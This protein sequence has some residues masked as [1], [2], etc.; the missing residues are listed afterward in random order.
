MRVLRRP[1][2]LDALAVLARLL[3]GGVWIW[4]G[5][6]K[7][8]DPYGAALAV[9]AYQI[10]PASV[11]DAVGHTLPTL[12]VVVGVA[13]VAGLLTRGAAVLS[14]LLFLAFVI[15]ISSVWARG[16]LIDCGCFGGGGFDPDAADRYPW[17]I[18]RDVALLAVSLFIVVAGNRRWALDRLLFRNTSTTSITTSTTEEA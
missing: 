8:T 18:A 13:L 4:A 6:A 15:G 12:E 7:I 10:L 2:L 9:R 1:G 16:I 17:E 3:T 11:A 5:L 14:A